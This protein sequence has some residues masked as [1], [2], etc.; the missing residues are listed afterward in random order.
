[1]TDWHQVSIPINI[2]HYGFLIA[3][4]KCEWFE[5]PQSQYLVSLYQDSR[6][7]LLSGVATIRYDQLLVKSGVCQV[8][9]SIYY[10]F[11]SH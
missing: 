7:K 9:L 2:Y 5:S 6:C 10:F 8:S 11:F 4:V 3:V 1:M